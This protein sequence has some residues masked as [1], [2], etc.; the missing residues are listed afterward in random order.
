MSSRI[1]ILL[2]HHK[3]DGVEIFLGNRAVA[4]LEKLY[5]TSARQSGT[6]V[7]KLD[8]NGVNYPAWEPSATTP[9]SPPKGLTNWRRAVWLWKQIPLGVQGTCVFRITR[10]GRKA[11]WARSETNPLRNGYPRKAA[12][13]VKKPSY[14]TVPV[15]GGG[16]SFS[17]LLS[18]SS[19]YEPESAP[20][21]E[22][23]AAAKRK[24][25]YLSQTASTPKK[26]T[27]HLTGIPLGIWAQV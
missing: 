14:Y 2:T 24:K 12:P 13:I 4:A 20:P 19:D 21:S 27:R 6:V 26:K 1:R 3:E 17:E 7:Y 25:P 11:T 15:S 8:E 18:K 23:I 5:K 9:A 10:E 22:V 16:V